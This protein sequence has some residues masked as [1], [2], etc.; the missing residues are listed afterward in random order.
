MPTRKDTYA[1]KSGVASPSGTLD[2]LSL[3]F[4]FLYQYL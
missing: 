1:E 2:I 4:Y 3:F